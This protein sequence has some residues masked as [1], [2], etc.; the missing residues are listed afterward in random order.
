LSLVEHYMVTGAFGRSLPKYC[1]DLGINF[2]PIAKK[3]GIEDRRFYESESSV[4]L[5]SFGAMLE[6][7][8]EFSNDDSFGL[9][10]GLNFTP[11][12]SGPYGFGLMNAPDMAE[13]I[14][15]MARFISLVADTID[16]NF[17]EEPN[18]CR[19]E[20]TYSPLFVAKDQYVDLVTLL[21]IFHLR[22]HVEPN[23]RP[24]AVRLQRSPPSSI[25]LHKLYMSSNLSFNAECNVIEFSCSQVSRKNPKADHRL[26]QIM[27][28]QCEA[29]LEQRIKTLPLELRVREKILFSLETGGISLIDVASQLYITERSLQ[30]RLAESGTNFERVSD[31]VRQEFSEQLQRH[32]K[33][34][35]TEIGAR[36]GFSTPGSYSRATKRWS[37]SKLNSN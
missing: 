20:W 26:Y 8:A 28:S 2:S 15:F 5:I 7:L 9:K 3:F 36:L 12:D 31:E 1:N 10:Y 19:I 4:S 11:G 13:A 34:T 37:N 21:A 29:K 25:H 27:Q 22:H 35:Q 30:R 33:L 6:H 24:I 14:R 17:I 18:N 16:F 23:W 32:S